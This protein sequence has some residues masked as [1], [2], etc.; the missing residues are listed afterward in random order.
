MKKLTEHDVVIN[1]IIHS[2]ALSCNTTADYIQ[3]DCRKRYLASYP[4][5]LCFLFAKVY[6]KRKVS[7]IGYLVS[8]KDH[9]TVIHGIKTMVS[10]LV[11]EDMAV[12]EMFNSCR[13]RLT[14]G[15]TARII[16]LQNGL[17]LLKRKYYGTIKKT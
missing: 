10:M 4:R 3:S 2:V 1:E 6:T 8:G 14:V 9:T 12:M 15:N 7:E 11:N 17:E 13:I 5:M 16:Q